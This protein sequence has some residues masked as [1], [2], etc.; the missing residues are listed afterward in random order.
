MISYS[1]LQFGYSII[2]Y[3]EMQFMD[4]IS[5]FKDR[6]H[7]VQFPVTI[8]NMWKSQ[9]FNNTG[10]LNVKPEISGFF[11]LIVTWLCKI[12]FCHVQ[13]KK[14]LFYNQDVSNSVKDES[15]SGLRDHVGNALMNFSLASL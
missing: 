2:V 6:L 14:V 10:I 3:S 7:N 1:H 9:I 11:S 4:G 13:S 12:K 8:D 5:S 15:A